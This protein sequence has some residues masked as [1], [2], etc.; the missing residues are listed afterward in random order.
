MNENAFELFFSR[1]VTRVCVLV[2]HA[3]KTSAREKE[4][5]QAKSR[6]HSVLRNLVSATYKCTVYVRVCVV[7]AENKLEAL[8]K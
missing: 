6:L 4:G 3:T 8:W 2:W 1:V 7:R 5:E